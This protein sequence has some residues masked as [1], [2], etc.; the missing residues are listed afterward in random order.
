VA[1]VIQYKI[2][3]ADAKVSAMEKK[4]VPVAR[5][6]EKSYRAANNG[7]YAPKP[8]DLLPYFATPQAGADWVEFIEATKAAA[9]ARSAK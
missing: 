2:D 3:Q 5:A 8:E 1:R 7:R 6:A 4:V 9:A